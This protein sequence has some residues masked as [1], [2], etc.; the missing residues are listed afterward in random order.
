L[1]HEGIPGVHFR[2]TQGMLE[3]DGR[4]YYDYPL[5]T[6]RGWEHDIPVTQVYVTAPDELRLEVDFPEGRGVPR[7]RGSW[8][9]VAEGI[10]GRQIH[11]VTYRQARPDKDVR[12]A[13]RGRGLTPFQLAQWGRFG[14]A[15]ATWV[16]FPALA[17][18]AWLVVFR[19]M[20]WKG[21]FAQGMGFWGGLLKSWLA[22]QGALLW[23]LA[24]VAALFAFG[25]AAS[26]RGP[27]LGLA[28]FVAFGLV[29]V[30]VSGYFLGRIYSP[31]TRDFMWQSAGASVVAAIV[32]G[33]AGLVALGLMGL[34]W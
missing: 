17:F 10:D 30:V 4:H 11:A 14:R 21:P 16:G 20:I 34:L 1:K 6:G 27:D 2:F 33:V 24:G 29:V 19:T 12:V 18:L 26:A 32:Y 7:R 23:A 31:Q 8:Y 25:C 9:K 5:G 13:L 15:A 22:G 3:E 28:L